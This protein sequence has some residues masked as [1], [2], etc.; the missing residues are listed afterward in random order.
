MGK[1]LAKLTQEALE[2]PYRQRAALAHSLY[3]SL[4]DHDEAEAAAVEQE[5]EEEIRRRLQEL[6]DGTV[7]TIPAWQVLAELRAKHAR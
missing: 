5:W 3:V 6:E 1:P 2:L 4:H 7:E